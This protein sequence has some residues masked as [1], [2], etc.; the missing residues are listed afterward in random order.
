[1]V[2]ST[3]PRTKPCRITLENYFQLV[4]QL[5]TGY[6][7]VGASFLQLLLLF[8]S[9]SMRKCKNIPPAAPQAA[10]SRH[11]FILAEGNAFTPL[12]C[13][14]VH[15]AWYACLDRWLH[16][17]TLQVSLF[18]SLSQLPAI[19]K[20]QLQMRGSKS[21]QKLVPKKTRNRQSSHGK[22]FCSFC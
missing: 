16:I 10:Q 19:I 4:L 17:A 6:K 21:N 11:S 15:I 20:A 7:G 12:T 8:M 18:S 9:Y 14:R 5:A 13:P 3:R 1:M 2:K 22:F